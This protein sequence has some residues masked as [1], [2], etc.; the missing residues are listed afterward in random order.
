MV[1]AEI[2]GADYTKEKEEKES[3]IHSPPLSEHRT[4]KL[5]CNNQI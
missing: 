3:F 1:N 4:E 2:I 5:N